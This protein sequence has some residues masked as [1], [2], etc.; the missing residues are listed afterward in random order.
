MTGTTTDPRS[1]TQVAE[2]RAI[3]EEVDAHALTCAIW[4]ALYVAQCAD[5]P[6][7]VGQL[8]AL[9]DAAV[10]RERELTA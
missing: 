6:E 9:R 8:C 2:R 4:L 1:P 3:S 10:K 7:A 5:W